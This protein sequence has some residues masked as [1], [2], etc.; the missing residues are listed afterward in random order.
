MPDVQLYPD[1]ALSGSG[2]SHLDSGI[3]SFR[4]GNPA[5][6]LY[7]DQVGQSTNGPDLLVSIEDYAI[8]AGAVMTHLQVRT[9]ARNSS[10]TDNARV[11]VELFGSNGGAFLTSTSLDNIQPLETVEEYLNWDGATPAN[12]I[13]IRVRSGLGWP[14]VEEIRLTLTYEY[15][16]APTTSNVAP[17]GGTYTSDRNPNV[18]WTFTGGYRGQGG[19]T[20][21]EAKIW[22][23]QAVNGGGWGGPD[24]LAGLSAYSGVVPSSGTSWIGYPVL[25]NTTYYVFVRTYQTTNGLQVASPWTGSSPFAIA[26]PNPVVSSIAPTGTTFTTTRRPTVTWNY[27]QSADGSDQAYYE[28]KVWSNAYRFGGSWINADQLAGLSVHTGVVNSAAKS[29]SIP[30]GLPNDAYRTWVRAHQV[31]EGIGQWS[32]WAETASTWTIAIPAPVTSAV[33]VSA[34]TASRTPTISWTY[35]QSSDG[36][37]QAYYQML[38]FTAA[39][40]GAGG[41]NPD[42]SPNIRNTGA[43]PSSAKSH[44]ITSPFDNGVTHKAY[45]RTY[46]VVDG[47]GMWSAWAFSAAFTVAIPVPVPTAVTPNAAGTT[48]KPAVGASVAA[49]ATGVLIKREWQVATDNVFT[50]SAQSFVEGAGALA[51]TKA[52]TIPFPFAARLP[53]GA[54]F[55]RARTVDQ[56]GQL[57]AY[58]AAVAFS[59]AHVPTIT[60]RL[61][62]AGTYMPYSIP[63][64]VTWVFADPDIAAGEDYQTKYQVQLWKTSTPGSPIDSGLVTSGAAYHDFALPDATWVDTQLEWKVLVQDRDAVSS[65]YTGS[66]IIWARMMWYSPTI[67]LAAYGAAG[68]TLVS[69]VVTPNA[70]SIVVETSIDLGI[71]WQAVT[72]GSVVPGLAAL[73]YPP[74]YM[75]I[76]VSVIGPA[77]YPVLTSLT[78][79]IGDDLLIDAFSVRWAYSPPDPLQ[80]SSDKAQVRRTGEMTVRSSPPRWF[81]NFNF[82]FV[83]YIEIYT[84]ALGG[85]WMRFNLGRLYNTLPS[86]SDDGS[87]VTSNFKLADRTYRFST[88]PLTEPMQIPLGTNPITWITASLTALGETL[89]LLPV[90][91]VVTTIQITFETNET[92]LT[93]YN[94]L[95]EA[96]GFTQLIVTEE[97]Y[98]T[99]S[100]ATDLSLRTSEWSYA[101]GGTMLVEAEVEPQLDDV[102]NEIRF[103]PMRGGNSLPVEGNGICTRRNQSTGP[104]SIDVR[105]RTVSVTVSVEAQNQAALELIANSEAQRIFAGGGYNLSFKTAWNPLHSDSDV[106]T[107]TKPRLNIPASIWLITEWSLNLGEISSPDDV[108][109]S[110]RAMRR[111][112]LT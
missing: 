63:L 67:S 52:G 30:P 106:V 44:V 1:N 10:S 58:T 103:V 49:M 59:I 76:R 25:S 66:Q 107:I 42:T 73:A 111:V 27:A 105:G 108:T 4:D 20:H 90:T 36:S 92:Y 79:T 9:R 18:S 34:V 64:R 29:A 38:I 78:L 70:G 112:A 28:L 102:P 85:S 12:E 48:S 57:S 89:F 5:T 11:N 77:P 37:D 41:F 8:P 31:V 109:M 16:A 14:H 88:L 24:S 93:V 87:V 51:S 6:Y 19:Q 55:I 71:T 74:A 61:P 80:S 13:L 95:L 15:A 91:T 62:P 22:T 23:N 54:W 26:I 53:Q 50:V 86:V 32:A 100:V 60:T 2:G 47:V 21:F 94:T 97:G 17:N 39:Q 68:A 96:C 69:W 35:S 56:F 83:P 98:F 84:E 82:I 3:N 43:V 72:Q 99:C 45:V 65:G 104:S 46:Q 40:Y 33:L 81:D 75:L 110:L 101:P 7:W